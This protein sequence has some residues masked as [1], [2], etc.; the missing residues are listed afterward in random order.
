MKSC[1]SKLT[2]ADRELIE[3]AGTMAPF[4]VFRK[5]DGAFAGA[6]AFID[7]SRTHRH[8]RIGYLW[9]RQD[10]RGTVVTPATQLV[11]PKRALASGIPRLE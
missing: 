10:M 1:V 2:D 5:S 9:H 3:R 6:A 7:I 4:K 8:V 11:M